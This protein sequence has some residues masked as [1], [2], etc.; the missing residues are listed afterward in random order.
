VQSA[1]R[2]GVDGIILFSYDSLTDP[3]RGA[4]YLALVGRAAFSS[5]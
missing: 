4:D 1:R 3:A 5:Q 2:Q